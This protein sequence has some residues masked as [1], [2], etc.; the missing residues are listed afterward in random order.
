MTKLPQPR[1]RLADSRDRFAARAASVRRRPW[2]LG[3]IVT[4][5]IALLVAGVWVLAF[6]SLLDV[7]TVSVSG[8]A[9]KEA[10]AITSA[11]Q[12]PMTTPLIRVDIQAIEER[13]LAARK[14]V[15]SV[16]VT[17]QYPH[18]IALSVTLRTPALVLQGANGQLE[19]VDETGLSY[20]V[21]PSR[22]AGVP[23]VALQGA[24]TTEEGLRTAL[25]ALR[26]LPEARR[27]A[28]QDITVTTSGSVTMTIGRT[29]VMWGGPGQEEKKA[30]LVD[31]L[32]GQE[33][34]PVRIDVSAPDTPVT[35]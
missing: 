30:R 33:P 15:K 10:E 8:A 20:A 19:V 35:R 23:L 4:G 17:R 1:A 28:V 13:I 11:A 34:T 21:V 27:K 22:P 26:I 12:V 3:A 31:I 6:S 25:G 7:R 9:G 24:S 32:L 18:T 29:T 16:T 14:P 5:V 2:L